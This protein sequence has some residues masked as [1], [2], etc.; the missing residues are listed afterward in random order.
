MRA[1][2]FGFLTSAPNAEVAAIHPKALSVI[3]LSRA[4][5]GRLDILV[6]NAGVNTLAH[7]VQGAATPVLKPD[8]LLVQRLIAARTWVAITSILTRI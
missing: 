3:L 6:N 1:D 7:R 4:R 2:L 5:A 8:P